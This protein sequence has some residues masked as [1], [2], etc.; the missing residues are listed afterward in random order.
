MT[1]VD[2]T[3][4]ASFAGAF[5]YEQTDIPPGQTIT[6]WRR[7]RTQRE[8]AAKAARS[9]ARRARLQALVTFRRP[10]RQR[11]VTAARS[12]GASR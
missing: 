11:S 7:E 6:E 5:A 1:T 12:A 8:R 9:Q 3:Q 10:T 4:P 2:L